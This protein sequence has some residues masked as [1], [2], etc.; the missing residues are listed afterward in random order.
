MLRK[1]ILRGLLTEYQLR[2]VMTDFWF[3]HFNVDPD[4]GAVVA[5]N[6]EILE[7]DLRRLALGKF[8][9]ILGAA[10]K[11]PAVL[12]NLDNTVSDGGA[13]NENF[14]REVMELYTTGP[15]HSQRD[16]VEAARC[17]SGLSYDSDPESETF[18]QFRYYPELHSKGAKTVLGHQFGEH[19]SEKVLDMLA[20]HSATGEFLCRKIAVRLV[21]DDP[22]ETLVSKM[23]A[24]FRSSGGHIGEVVTEMLGSQEFRDPQNFAA[25]YKTSTEF[26][27]S[28][29]A[30]ADSPTL[31]KELLS[32]GPRVQ[33]LIDAWLA[34][35]SP[36]SC[37]NPL[38]WPDRTSVWTSSVGFRHRN[39]V[40]R[41]LSRSFQGRPEEIF[42]R[43]FPLGVSASTRVVL[44]GQRETPEAF[45]AACLM[46]PEF[47]VR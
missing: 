42:S 38:G 21:T 3:N 46:C 12:E 44:D 2:E 40:A 17:F 9:D 16:V 47:Q 19:E 37:P 6:V 18:L 15:V 24:T 4:K 28:A 26:M 20:S 11:N 1:R 34:M 35:G 36:Y 45:L 23:V 7:S 30:A 22:P 27:I 13:V 33:S 5:C 39:L 31:R 25:K 8:R 29:F 43:L 41:I 32:N 14:G 10:I